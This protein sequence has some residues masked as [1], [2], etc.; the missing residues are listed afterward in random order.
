M[1]V[2][3][4]TY[5]HLWEEHLLHEQVEGWEQGGEDIQDGFTLT[6]RTFAQ[7]AWSVKINLQ[8]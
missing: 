5:L 8:Q 7:P 3:Q 1:C 4:C 6:R 2:D